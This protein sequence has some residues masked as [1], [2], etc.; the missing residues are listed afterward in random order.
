[1][2]LIEN[3]AGLESDRAFFLTAPYA[4]GKSLIATYLLHLIQNRPEAKP[5][6]R[7]IQKRLRPVGPEMA[8]FAERRLR[9]QKMGGIAIVLEGYQEDI[10]ESLKQAGLEALSRVKMGRQAR[11][12]E[13][14]DASGPSGAVEVLGAICDKAAQAKKDRVIIVWDEFGRHLE[15]LVAAGQSAKIG[16]ISGD[17]QCHHAQR[18]VELRW[19]NLSNRAFHMAQSRGTIPNDAICR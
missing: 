8:K 16:D 9:N 4:S 18:P 12:I 1:V 3:L 15:R 13:K 17:I 19:F 5:I 7:S 14:I 6:L 2:K 11:A 10:G